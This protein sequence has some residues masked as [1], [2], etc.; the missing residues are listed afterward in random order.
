M[1]LTAKGPLPLSCCGNP[2]YSGSLPEAPN[3]AAAINVSQCGALPYI[4]FRGDPTRVR[5]F[6]PAHYHLGTNGQFGPGVASILAEAFSCQTVSVDGTRPH[7]A[8]LALIG[9]QVTRPTAA[10][11]IADVPNSFFDAYEHSPIVF[12]N[13]M[14]LYLVQAQTND[15]TLGERLSSAGFP[16]S[17]VSEIDLRATTSGD[18]L[19]VRGGTSPYELR[20]DTSLYDYPAGPHDHDNGWWYDSPG[21]A[22]RFLMHLHG[23]TD[24]NC[25]YYA[26]RVVHAVIPSCVATLSTA[27]DSGLAR[28]L[29]GASTDAGFA[30]HHLNNGFRGSIELSSGQRNWP[31]GLG[32]AATGPRTSRM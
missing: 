26:D 24:T 5:P 9:V 14:D 6:V 23:M 18:F 4:M 7:P 15:R 2:P 17:I 21:G 25:S 10:A 20:S 30:G 16:V 31:P 1:S 8:V 3:P 13:S 29:G 22:L 12:L 28:L 19:A 27:T 11:P 32:G